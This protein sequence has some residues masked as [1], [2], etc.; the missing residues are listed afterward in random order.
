MSATISPGLLDARRDRAR[1]A[2]SELIEQRGDY[3]PSLIDPARMVR[4]RRLAAEELALEWQYRTVVERA[5]AER[6][7]R[8]ALPEQPWHTL[9]NAGQ[10]LAARAAT[11]LARRVRATDGW[12]RGVEQ[13]CAEDCALAADLLADRLARALR[14]CA[15]R[16]A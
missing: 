10:S 16:R 1:A 2:V 7:V 5:R 4:I 15:Q 9:R 3:P 11:H 12:T 13:R 14:I 8:P 6:G